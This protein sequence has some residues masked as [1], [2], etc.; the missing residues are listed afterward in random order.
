MSGGGVRA[1]E[2]DA[3]WFEEEEEEEGIYLQLETCERVQVNEA[4]SKH[5]LA[6]PTETTSRRDNTRPPD[7]CIPAERR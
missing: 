3:S 4:K 1:L 2:E 7:A 5:R 6:S